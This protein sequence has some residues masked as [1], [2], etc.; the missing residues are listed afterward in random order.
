MSGHSHWATIKH[1][2]GALDAKKGKMFSKFARQLMVLAREGGDNP[3]FNVSLAKAIREAKQGGMPMDK[4][5]LAV[6]KGAGKV[7]GQ[8]IETKTYEGKGA[9]GVMIIVETM[10]DNA[11]RTAGEIRKLFERSNGALIN[12][13]AAVNQFERKGFIYIA[14]QGVKDQELE[15]AAIDAGADNIERQGEVW[16]IATSF[17]AFNGVVSTLEKKFKIEASKTPLVPKYDNYVA[18]SESDAR[19]AKHL[20]DLLEDHDDVQE[21]HHN[22]NIPDSVAAE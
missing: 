17:E 3:A 21:V 2:K 10:T 15:N 11:N 4:I 18:L 5:E 13:G 1:K 14:A 16:M 22:G 12:P 7:E 9:G 20:I 6:R 19:K 8:S